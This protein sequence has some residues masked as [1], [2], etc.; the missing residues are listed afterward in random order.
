MAL[1]TEGPVKKK[2]APQN[3]ITVDEL[4]AKSV[5]EKEFAA[6]KT[7]LERQQSITWQVVIGVAVAFILAIGVVITDGILSRNSNNYNAKSYSRE[8]NTN[9][10]EVNNLNNRVD[11]LYIRNPYLK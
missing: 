1:L 9:L 11:N 6:L 4:V 7:D 8:I 10:I 5:F 3:I 2:I